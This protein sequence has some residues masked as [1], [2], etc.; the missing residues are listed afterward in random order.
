MMGAGAG[1]GEWGVQYSGLETWAAPLKNPSDKCKFPSCLQ[2]SFFTGCKGP[3]M[4]STSF[5]T[6][7]GNY[8][9]CHALLLKTFKELKLKW[10]KI[11]ETKAECCSP[12]S[13]SAIGKM[14][15]FTE[16]LLIHLKSP[17]QSGL[18]NLAQ[19]PVYIFSGCN[20]RREIT[21]LDKW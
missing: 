14:V 16:V 7:G 15:L 4:K 9:G 13:S 6:P 12:C 19:R 10:P 21:G 1:V 8:T 17:P 2:E 3:T 5:E 11:S 18:S 20:L